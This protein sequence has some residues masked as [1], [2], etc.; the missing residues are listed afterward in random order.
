[1]DR[2]DLDERIDGPVLRLFVKTPLWTRKESWVELLL[3]TVR[4]YGG[5][6]RIGEDPEFLVGL[7]LEWPDEDLRTLVSLIGLAR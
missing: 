4:L 5:V 2:E 1:V 3:S 7:G 6:N